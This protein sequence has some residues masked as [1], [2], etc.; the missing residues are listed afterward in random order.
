MITFL[1][2]YLLS[3]VI[4]IYTF[5]KL[6]IHDIGIEILCMFIP[7]LNTSFAIISLVVYFIYLFIQ[8]VLKINIKFNLQSKFEQFLNWINT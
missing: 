4:I 3:I 5:K 8:S 2:V 6:P 1:L 7:I